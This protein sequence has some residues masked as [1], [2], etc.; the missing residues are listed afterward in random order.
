MNVGCVHHETGRQRDNSRADLSAEQRAIRLDVL[1][2]VGVVSVPADVLADI[3]DPASK[4]PIEVDEGD[5]E[6]R[7]QKR[8]DRALAGSTGA[9]QSNLLGDAHVT[10]NTDDRDGAGVTD[11][12]QAA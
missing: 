11:A 7:R 6:T 1:S 2:S 12:R 8:T 9:D 3:A 5:F 4:V 10:S